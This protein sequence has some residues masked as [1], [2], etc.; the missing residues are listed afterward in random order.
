M[1]IQFNSRFQGTPIPDEAEVPNPFY[2]ELIQMISKIQSSLENCDLMLLSG[3]VILLRD[4]SAASISIILRPSRISN[5]KFGH[6]FHNLIDVI[7]K[8]PVMVKRANAFFAQPTVHLSSP[9]DHL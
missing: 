9:S 8:H 5:L 4:A 3:D 1:F 6:S 7:Y 2:L